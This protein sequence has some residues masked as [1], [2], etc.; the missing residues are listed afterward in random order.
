MTYDNTEDFK[1]LLGL[2]RKAEESNKELDLFLSKLNHRNGQSEKML[3]TAKYFIE[4][5]KR[6]ELLKV[7][8]DFNKE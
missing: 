5:E 8:L 4:M 3:D 2:I 7:N 6:L 1:T